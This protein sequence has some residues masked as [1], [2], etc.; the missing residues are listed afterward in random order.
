MVPVSTA[1][2]PL[3]DSG[4][5]SLSH[6]VSMRSVVEQLNRESSCTH[7]TMLI[8]ALRVKLLFFC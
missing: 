3:L 1:L 6:I 2:I 7:Y 8:E 5:F 4:L